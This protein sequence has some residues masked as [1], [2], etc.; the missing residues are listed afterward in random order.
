MRA[1]AAQER[2]FEKKLVGRLRER[3]LGTDALERYRDDAGY[4]QK[5]ELVRKFLESCAGAG[6]V[7]DVG[8]NTAGE[9]EILASLGHRMVPTDV[10]E[11]ALACSKVRAKRF[12]GQELPYFAADAHCL[13]FAEDTFDKIV[14]FEA[15]HHMQDIAVVLAE[16]FRV[17]KPGG[18][19]F[20]CE[21]NAVNPYRRISELRDRFRGTHEA[22]FTEGGLV[23]LF[24]Q[25][26]FRVT[27]VCRLVLPPSQWKKDH[28]GSLRAGLKDL[29]FAVSRRLPLF[30]GSL[31]LRAQKPGTISSASCSLESRLRCPITG[32]P[33]RPL[34][35]AW[36]SSNETGPR[37][38]Y[39]CHQGVPVLIRED[40]QVWT[41]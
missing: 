38:L 19:L 30:F 37:Y 20:T 28:A 24:S 2:S 40:A 27:E 5:V 23:R 6:W 33:L 34:G 14:A 17:L 18:S 9:S 15:L 31:V 12:R 4:R 1:G 29:Y 22:S 25:A 8:A 41:A 35:E 36:L 32:S 13:P 11:V 26:G 39:P 7:L 16:L 21:P 3:Y 10:N